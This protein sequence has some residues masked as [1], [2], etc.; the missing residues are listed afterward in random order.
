MQLAN[1]LR[2]DKVE[3]IKRQNTW[4]GEVNYCTQQHVVVQLSQ[5]WKAFS[6]LFFLLSKS[7]W[8]WD[9]KVPSIYLVNYSL[10]RTSGIKG[11]AVWLI[12]H[13]ALCTFNQGRNI[14]FF[15]AHEAHRYLDMVSIFNKRSSDKITSTVWEIPFRTPAS[16]NGGCNSL[17]FK[18]KI[19][20]FF[21]QR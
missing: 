20:I 15:I 8:K 14:H 2:T 19:K 12:T 11:M 3:S 13:N 4:E 17:Y 7:G 16:W 21:Q 6:S 1:A 5:K 10:Q 9:F 18:I